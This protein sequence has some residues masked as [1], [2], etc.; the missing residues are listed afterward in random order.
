MFISL[1][2][3]N[4]PLNKTVYIDFDKG[5]NVLHG[6]N[7]SGKS[8][9]IEMLNY[10]LFGSVALRSAI[11]T[12]AKDF[13]VEAQLIINNLTYKINRTVKDSQLYLYDTESNK[14]LILATGITPVNEYMKGLLTYDYKIF[15][16]TNF[17]KQHDLL[18]LTSCSPTELV[19][20]IEVVS[21]LDSSY[22]LLVSLKE[23]RKEAKAVVKSLTSTLANASDLNIEFE[24]NETF[25]A[26]LK[27][28]GEVLNNLQRVLDSEYQNS[29]TF[30]HLSDALSKNVLKLSE[31]EDSEKSVI[32]S[33]D[34]N[35]T[36]EE[37]T[38]LS[39]QHRTL[40]SQISD[41]TRATNQYTIPSTTYPEE[42]LVNQE[43]LI[44]LELEYKN[45]LKIK[46]QL[47]AHQVTCPNCEHTFY[48]SSLELSDSFDTAPE[49]P[50]LT[51]R[52]IA[53]MREWNGKEEEY[54]ATI[55]SLEA[56]KEAKSAC[57]DQQYISDQLGLYVRLESNNSLR[58]HLQTEIEKG[59]KELVPYGIDS[60][61]IIKSCLEKQDELKSDYEKTL[62][63]YNKFKS[64]VASK[65]QYLQQQQ[66]LASFKDELK[67][68]SDNLVTYNL[69]Y[70]VLIQ[71]KKTVQ[72]ESF[73]IINSV[74]S[75]IVSQITGGE[76]NKVF[77]NDSF[78]IEVDDTSVETL[79]GS[80]K[81]IANLALRIALLNTFY[82]DTF[83]VCLFDEIDE[84][85]HED[86]FEY[87]EESFNKLAEQG[88]QLI[89]TSHKN[90]T[91]DKIINMDEFKK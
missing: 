74:A 33:I 13:E 66:V 32:S 83:L 77:I 16:L 61:N 44:S 31:L 3:K 14:F 48:N 43:Q 47:E 12:Y 2:I 1:S 29:E 65:H 18:K 71:I 22:K 55:S 19:N 56:V 11:S 21:G 78:K 26:L 86:R 58:S 84:S 85:L 50:S 9:V 52:M 49:E 90:Y 39:E 6:K 24:P 81:V 89:L 5:I 63:E 57:V 28:N 23:S 42:F 64:Y 27:E 8:T 60:D 45:F 91:V 41:L 54:N 34:A 87:M 36:L 35:Y 67:T 73:P 38:A 76:R 7:S 37:L 69:L 79:E 17:C 46:K 4:S 15:S 30:K 40:N 88:Y 70:D 82:K 68:N 75:D 10:S 53:T 25:D 20:L 51:T 62:L 72:T 59:L 80:G